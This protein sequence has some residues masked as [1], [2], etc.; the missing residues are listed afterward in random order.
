MFE[1]VNVREKHPREEKY[2]P[3][4]NET[5]STQSKTRKSTYRVFKPVGI[6]E[7]HPREE[8]Y[9]PEENESTLTHSTMK[10]STHQNKSKLRRTAP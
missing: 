2:T 8:K 1:P 3:I 9:T 7:K 5:T 10:K 4:E 6:R